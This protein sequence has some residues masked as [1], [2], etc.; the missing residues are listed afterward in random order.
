MSLRTFYREWKAVFPESPAEYLLNLRMQEARQLLRITS[1]RI[2][3][4]ADACGYPNVIYFS[5]VFAKSNGM[6]PQA[7]R[8]LHLNK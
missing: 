5:R 8:K 7:Y 6:T 3:E 4:V 1:L 2:Y